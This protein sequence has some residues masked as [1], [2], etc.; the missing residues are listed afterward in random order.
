MLEGQA[1]RIQDRVHRIDHVLHPHIYPMILIGIV[2]IAVPIQIRDR[3][4]GEEGLSVGLLALFVVGIR[5]E[6][7]ATGFEFGLVLRIEIESR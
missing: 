7:A 6:I 2:G 3:I 4:A 5:E 1:R